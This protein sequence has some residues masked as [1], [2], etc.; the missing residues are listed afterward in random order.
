MS[1]EDL[2]KA[3]LA[4]LFA[5]A[6][7]SDAGKDGRLAFTARIADEFRGQISETMAVHEKRLREEADR[8]RSDLVAT[9][10]SE[11]TKLRGDLESLAAAS[12]A[13]A[14]TQAVRSGPLGGVEEDFPQ[15]SD[16]AQKANRAGQL[17][18]KSPGSEEDEQA[19]Q[20][21]APKGSGKGLKAYLDTAP[22]SFTG[23]MIILLALFALIGFG[24][25]WAVFGREPADSGEAANLEQ[26]CASFRDYSSAPKPEATGA[27]EGNGIAQDVV[28][29]PQA[30]P[31]TSLEQM[32]AAKC[33]QAGTVSPANAPA[34]AAA[35]PGSGG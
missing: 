22:A 26:I 25:S 3:Q 15:K 20:S 14:G 17:M 31:L 16:L 1:E 35:T 4:K 21:P 5:D 32:L 18:H 23:L 9:M 10:T 11:R 19:P 29:S 34:P 2:I 8:L 33:L 6:L 30:G 7:L 12:I 13:G 27:E 24:A 28:G